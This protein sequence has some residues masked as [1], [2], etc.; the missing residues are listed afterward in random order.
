LLDGLSLHTQKEYRAA[1]T[2]HDG[3]W[4]LLS[5]DSDPGMNDAIRLLAIK[6]KRNRPTVG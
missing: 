3:K 2:Y 4:L 1:T 5:I 6:R